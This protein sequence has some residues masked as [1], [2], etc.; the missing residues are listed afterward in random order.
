MNRHVSKQTSLLHSTSPS[1]ADVRAR[2]AQ[3]PRGEVDR[4]LPS[5]AQHDHNRA[6]HRIGAELHE[7]S[8]DQTPYELQPDPALKT[9]E[10][11]YVKRVRGRHA[12]PY[13]RDRA[14][15]GSRQGHG[16]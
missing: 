8:A 14:A 9:K 7:L 12:A 6:R 10:N 1:S 16:L 15:R 3:V 2:W 4:T 5:V 13:L 11:K